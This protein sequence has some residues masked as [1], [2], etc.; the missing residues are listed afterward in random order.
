MGVILFP[1]APRNVVGFITCT[2][3]Y[4]AIV[5]LC[6]QILNLSTAVKARG[7]FKSEYLT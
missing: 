3:M 4:I 6:Y 5:Y 2:L 1:M 7:M